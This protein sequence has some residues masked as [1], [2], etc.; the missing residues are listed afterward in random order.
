METKNKINNIFLIGF[1]GS[2]KSKIGKTLSKVL[3]FTFIDTDRKIEQ[4]K[5]KKIHEIID[6]YGENYF[7]QFE[8]EILQKID[9]EKKIFIFE[10]NDTYKLFVYTENPSIYT[11]KLVDLTNNINVVFYQ[12]SIIVSHSLIINEFFKLINYLKILS[13]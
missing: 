4:I 1:S 9:Y 2:G 7:R 3:N 11:I 10:N 8:T 12:N 13:H 5:Q 6:E